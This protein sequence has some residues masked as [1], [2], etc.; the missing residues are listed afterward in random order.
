ME[1]IYRAF[2]QQRTIFIGVLLLL[3]GSFAF[4]DGAAAQVRK[5]FTQRPSNHPDNLVNGQ[6]IKKIYNVKGDFAMIGNTNMRRTDETDGDNSNQRMKFVNVDGNMINSSAATLQLPAGID[7]NCTN[8]VFAGLYWSGR[9]NTDDMNVRS[10]SKIEYSYNDIPANHHNQT[11]GNYTRAIAY[12]NYRFAISENGDERI[13]TFSSTVPGQPTVQFKR[14]KHRGS[15]ITYRLGT[16]GTWLIPADG[17]QSSDDGITQTL[18]VPFVIFDGGANGAKL[19]LDQI[20]YR[21]SSSLRISVTG[22]YEVENEVPVYL[23]KRKVKIKGPGASQYTEFEAN[24]NDIRY[25]NISGEDNNQMYAG[26]VEITDYVKNNR[27]GEYTVAD[28][29]LFEGHGGAAGYYGGWGMVVIYENPT[30]KWRDVTIFDGFAYVA[31]SVTEDYTIDLQGFQAVENGPVNVTLGIMAGEGDRNIG[32]PSAPDYFEIAT[33]ATYMNASPTWE[34]LSHA[35]KPEYNFFNS[36]IFTGDNPRNPTL[37]NNVGVDISRFDIANTDNAII[38]NNQTGTKFRYGTNQDTYIIYNITFAVDAYIPEVEPEN[39]LTAVDGVPVPD[40]HS[41]S[42][43]LNPNEELTFTL[44]IKNTG[45]EPINNAVVNIPM[46]YTGT[47]VSS[48]GVGHNGLVPSGE[49]SFNPLTGILTWDLGVLPKLADPNAVLATLTYNV[50]VTDDCYILTNSGCPAYVIVDGSVSGTGANSGASLGDAGNFIFGKTNGGAS[51]ENSPIT[52]PTPIK[53]NPGAECAGNEFENRT[54]LFC[55]SEVVDGEIPVSIIRNQFPA[56]T[57]FYSDIDPETFQGIGTEYNNDNPFTG[58]PGSEVTYYGIPPR[59]EGSTCYFIFK[60]AVMSISGTPEITDPNYCVGDEASLLNEM[61]EVTS[62]GYQLFFYETETATSPID[63][64]VRPST[65]EP[66]V[67]TYWVA[68]GTPTCIGERV[69]LT[70][71]IHPRPEIIDQPIDITICEGETGSVSVTAAG[72]ELSYTWQYYDSN[73]GAWQNL[74]SGTPFPEVTIDGPTATLANADTI[75]NGGRLRVIVSGKGDCEVVSN[76]VTVTVTS[77]PAPTTDKV[78]QE[79]CQIDVPTVGDLIVEGTDIKWYDV[80]TGGDPLDVATV[81]IDGVTYYGTQTVDGCESVERLAVTVLLNSIDGGEISGSQTVC[82]GTT[83]AIITSLTPGTGSGDIVY[84]WESSI[85]DGTTWSPIPAVSGEQHSPST[86]TQTTSFR[87]IATSILNGVECTAYSN[88]VLVTINNDCAITSRKD[89]TDANGDGLANAGEQL[90]YTIA[91]NNTFDRDVTV[92]IVDQIPAHTVYL[93][94]TTGG[95]Y[96]AAANEITWNDL[97]VP[98]GTE[99]SVSFIVEVVDNLTGVSVIQNIAV[100]TGEVIETPQTPAVDIDT[101]PVK[102]FTSSKAAD[103]QSVSAGD[104]LT[105]T[106]TVTNTGD[107]DYGGIAIEDAIPANTVY[108]E[109]S[110]SAGAAI[111]GNTLSW[112]V[113]VPFGESRAVSFTVVVAENLTGV[114]AIRNVAVVTGDDPE[115]PEEPEVETPTDRVKSFTS[116]KAADKQSVSAGDELTY[117]ITVTNTGDVDYEG[118]AIEDAIPANTVYKEGSAS[119]GAAISGNT[120]SWTV[121]VPFGESRAVSFTVVVAE[122]LTGVEAIRNVAVVTGDDPETPE[123]PEVETP[124]TSDRRFESSK[125]VSDATGDGKAQAGEELLYTITVRNTGTEDYNGITIEDE[126]PAYTTY[127]AGSATHNATFS[128]GKLTWLINVGYGQ[129]V[130]VSFEVQVI[131]DLE[132]TEVIR[133]IATVTGG[134]PENPEV[135]HPESPE[136]PVITGPVA[137]NDEADTE[138]GEPVTIIVIDNDEAGNSPI[139]PASVRLVDPLTGD[140]VMSVAIEGEG[141]YAVGADGNV[142]F[143]PEAGYVG[144]STVNYTVK[145]ENGLESNEATISVTVEG[146]AAEVAPTA[147]D[148]HATTQYGQP[149]TIA[150]LNNDQPGSSPIAPSTVRLLDAN[151]N[152]VS[153]VT[154]PGEGRY[155]V[156]AQGIVTF[157]PADGFTGTSTV[158]YEVSDENGLVSNVANISVTV[159][160]RPF[161]IP[162]VFT[163]NGDGRNDVFEI[164]GL[165]AFDRVEITV[166]NRWGNEVYRNSNYRNNWDGQGLNEG[167]YYYVIILHEGG[168][169]ERHA[170]WVLIKRQ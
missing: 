147:V 115:T 94:N 47:Y 49:P 127:V 51:C 83:P 146:V 81:L 151:G 95:N 65:D 166:V 163:P 142:V 71:T 104:E 4:P 116:S 144:T 141:V 74:T 152:R 160:T 84:R 44:T 158:H 105:Y 139:V 38:G 60:I 91:V 165:E 10:S 68:Q 87:R 130:S 125:T 96:A 161:K 164:V 136:I 123:E 19:S 145:D 114:E 129:E 39:T 54:I 150:V 14:E 53:V 30:M 45:A 16:T 2:N 9:A 154:I 85:D 93:S 90:T 23:S 102:S 27:F 55:E 57:R 50:R 59:G 77:I 56:G 148:D 138:Q 169:Q 122:N 101:D 82:L 79:F 157:T 63:G 137:H 1:N 67:I 155:E 7:P 31:G 40:Q 24:V 113:D 106:I 70:I 13:Y 75:F 126:I 33:A 69:P 97:V 103:K 11:I 107:V 61:A 46:P 140:K 73:E 159:G 5:P 12:T 64:S 80:E 58:T 3:L 25:N 29:A 32:E 37:T 100:V 8:I 43:E 156:N 6:P 167:T 135:E 22:K 128:N 153:T 170:G 117:T 15:P 111:S 92:N 17:Q 124:V 41:P 99:I 28:L 118:I 48:A 121:D 134:T 168:R 119:A 18:D 89:V 143:T 120:L 86:L 26:Y 88:A 131:A 20:A 21:N 36:S 34:R 98:A 108:K 66:G 42:L 76:E 132:G 109:G 162:N 72:E 35:G 52:S 62:E 78:T 112:T 149:V 133:N 110:A